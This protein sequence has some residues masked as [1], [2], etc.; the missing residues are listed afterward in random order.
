MRS[1]NFPFEVA[2]W[3]LG[4]IPKHFVLYCGYCFVLYDCVLRILV[5]RHRGSAEYAPRTYSALQTAPFP[6]GDVTGD[7][8]IHRRQSQRGGLSDL[9]LAQSASRSRMEWGYWRHFFIFSL[10]RAVQVNNW[11]P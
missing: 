11:F 8:P 5:S 1:R 6:D 9:G 7:T 4:S 3:S 2:W 10:A